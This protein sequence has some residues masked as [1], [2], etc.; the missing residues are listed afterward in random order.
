M[1][2]AGLCDVCGKVASG[3]SCKLCGKRV[4]RNC[5]TVSGTCKPC[6]GGYNIRLDE[7]V[8]RRVLNEKGLDDTRI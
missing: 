4:C 1:D 3:F 8:V 5:V 6:A 7:D 2:S